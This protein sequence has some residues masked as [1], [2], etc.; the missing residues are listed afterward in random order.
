MDVSKDLIAAS[1][2]PLI[3]AILRQQDSYGYEIIKRIR[4]ASDDELVWTEGMLYPVLHRLEKNGLV[5]SYW[6]KSEAGRRRKYYR[7]K[8]AGLAELEDHR[9]QWELVYTVLSRKIYGDPERRAE[10]DV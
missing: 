3:L 6:K 9:R 8:E 5:E 7:L 2:T 10:S 1:A 4:E